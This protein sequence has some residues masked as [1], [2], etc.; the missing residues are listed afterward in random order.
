MV[1]VPIG[2]GNYKVWKLGDSIHSTPTIVAAPRA[3]YDLIYGDSTYNAFYQQYRSRRQV[4]YIGAN[5]GI[6]HAFNAGFYHKGDNPATATV[7]EH[8]WFTNTPTDNSS[9]VKLGD[10][11]WGFVPHQLL[12]QLQWLAQGPTIHMCTTLI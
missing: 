8:G 4:L 10:E 2:S 6:L 7:V 1:E 5:D 9:S 12:P 11:L 3:R